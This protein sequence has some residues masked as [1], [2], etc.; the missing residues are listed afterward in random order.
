MKSTELRELTVND[1]EEKLEIEEKALAR[2]K[3]Q[4]SISGIDSPIE[5][6][7]RRKDIARIKT[8]L[9]VRNNAEK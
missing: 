8:E 9:N 4:H 2:Q 7:G 6:R 1:L 3:F 5:L